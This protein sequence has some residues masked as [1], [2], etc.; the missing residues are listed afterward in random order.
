MKNNRT[1]APETSTDRD[2][3]IG[4]LADFQEHADVV[5]RAKSHIESAQAGEDRF[6]EAVAQID[7]ALTALSVTVPALLRELDRLDEVSEAV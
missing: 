7:A 2:F 1:I 5:T 3:L 6:D 4:L